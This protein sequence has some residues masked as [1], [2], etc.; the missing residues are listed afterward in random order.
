[1]LSLTHFE[2][3]ILLAN[4]INATFALYNLAIFA[5]LFYGCFYSHCIVVFFFI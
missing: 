5:A 1:M 2:F 3:R 4:Y